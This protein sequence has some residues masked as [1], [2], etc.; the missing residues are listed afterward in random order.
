[1]LV[2]RGRSCVRCAQPFL[3][4][5][6]CDRGDWYC[7]DECSTTAR[8]ESRRRARAKHQASPEG[9]ADH[10]DRMRAW[11]AKQ[12][13]R[14]TDH[15]SQGALGEPILLR[16]AVTARLK[17]VWSGPGRQADAMEV[18]TRTMQGRCVMCGRRGWVSFRP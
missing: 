3:I 1:M 10:R 11:R 12:R 5:K 13:A 14:V 6:S 18:R 16:R 4:C 7:G 8:R 17:A 9:R 2:L 15:G